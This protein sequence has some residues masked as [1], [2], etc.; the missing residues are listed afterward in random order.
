V[1]Y[2][3]LRQVENVVD[4]IEIHLRQTFNSNLQT[5]MTEHGK[6]TGQ[7]SIGLSPVGAS[8]YYYVD[9]VEPQA[10]PAIFILPDKS[11]HPMR[12]DQWALQEHTIFVAVLFEDREYNYMQRKAWRYGEAL[13][14]SLHDQGVGNA[15]LL[16]EEI[17]YGPTVGKTG[18]KETRQFRK[19]VM[20]RVRAI[21][22]EPFP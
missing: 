9:A 5:I 8:F 17:S 1:A 20:A 14:R 7:G 13:F 22:L 12:A 21:H 16:V 3:A 18:D 10:L 2:P 6:V 15:R 11:E 4:A 19:D